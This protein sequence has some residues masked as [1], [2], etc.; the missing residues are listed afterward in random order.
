MSAKDG[1]GADITVGDLVLVILASERPYIIGRVMEITEGGVPVISTPGKLQQ[2][3]KPGV[4]KIMSPTNLEF[5]PGRY[6]PV[7]FKLTNP[8]NQALID[9]LAKQANASA[10][11]GVGG[12]VLE[13]IDKAK[14]KTEGATE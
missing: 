14:Q 1:I 6:I 4:M 12:S 13:M 3:T 5:V 10:G 7:V 9:E 8:I 2:Q 11:P